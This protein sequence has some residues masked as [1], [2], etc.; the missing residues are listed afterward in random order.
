[1]NDFEIIDEYNVGIA[2]V[3]IVRYSSNSY[4][5]LI[6]E[7]LGKDVEGMISRNVDF[8]LNSIP[9]GSD[10]DE[11][12]LSRIISDVLKV[13]GDDSVKFI[14]ALR[15]ELKYKKFQVLIDD[16][17]IEDISVAG[18][19]P[20]WVRHSK[21]LKI[22]PDADY[23]PTNVVLSDFDEVLKYINLF[24]EKANKII[25]KSLPILDAN[26]PDADGGHRIHLVL[27]EVSLGRPE[28]TIRK[29][30]GYSTL[31]IK[32]LIDD[33]VLPDSVAKYL[34]M[35]IKSRGS[36]VIVGPPG[37]GKTTLLRAL[38]YEFIPPTWKI[39]I[40]EDTPEIDP[41]PQSNWIR[42]IVP[43]TLAAANHLDQ[44]AL[45][46]AA[47]RSSV[48]K[49]IVVG[50]TRGAEA[51]VLVQAMNMGLGG[52]TTFHGGNVKEAIIRLSG[53][54]IGLSNHQISMFWSFV[55]VNFVFSGKSVKRAVVSVDEPIY[56]AE[57]DNI[58]LNNIYS[59]G[60]CSSFDELIK[61]SIR[62]RGVSYVL[63]HQ[64]SYTE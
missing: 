59:F 46:K 38:L 17:Y 44:F 3:K 13:S 23:I 27:H 56:D 21:V 40:I 63:Q 22:D 54:P 1:M 32:S 49:Y 26:L 25:S 62:L 43:T 5:Y 31:S 53:P 30:R 14:Y 24:A 50:E 8:I 57:T 7:I 47:L 11:L 10:L 15:K 55:T 45:S 35:V 18:V 64:L 6:E 52:L 51:Q 60:D 29:K 41:L 36:I 39:V 58:I 20:V 61:R 48:N 4:Q 42:Y 28:I 9:P 2:N 33:E 19:G 34:N 16:P 12:T 37:S